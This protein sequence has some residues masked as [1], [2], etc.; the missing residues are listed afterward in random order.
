L[1]AFSNTA[2]AFRARAK[3]SSSNLF[4]T[5]R[6]ADGISTPHIRN[7]DQMLA[8]DKRFKEAE[9]FMS[10]YFHQDWRY[11]LEEAHQPPTVDGAIAFAIE[12]CSREALQETVTSLK[13]ILQEN[14]SEEILEDFFCE[15]G[16]MEYDPHLAGSTFRTFTQYVLDAL[17][18]SSKLKTT[19]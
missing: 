10:G 17:L 19:L 12:Q 13:K 2:K 9:Q 6:R 18:R 1:V 14:P 8:S 5:T 3:N 4:K 16:G 11:I 15:Q 7:E